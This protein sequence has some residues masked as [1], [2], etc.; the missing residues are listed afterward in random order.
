[1]SSM[2]SFFASLAVL[3]TALGGLWLRRAYIGE[4]RL[5]MV[6]LAHPRPER[7]AAGT[8][9]FQAFLGIAH[10]GLGIVWLLVILSKNHRLHWPPF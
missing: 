3:Y 6:T 2:T 5:L 8:R 7:E 10:L 9:F 4:K 1:M